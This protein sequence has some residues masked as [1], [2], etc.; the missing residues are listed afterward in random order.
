VSPKEERISVYSISKEGRKGHKVWMMV[1]LLV[2][3]NSASEKHK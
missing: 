2:A 3:E 1:S